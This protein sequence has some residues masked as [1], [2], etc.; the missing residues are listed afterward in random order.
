MDGGQKRASPVMTT[1][2][3]PTRLSVSK[4]FNFQFYLLISCVR[5]ENKMSGEDN[6]VFNYPTN[7]IKPLKHEENIYMFL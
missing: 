5:R 1:N 4:P 2:Y 3:A 6:F 7:S